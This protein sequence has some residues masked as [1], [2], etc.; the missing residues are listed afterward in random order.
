MT[1]A[2]SEPD[3]I[4]FVDPPVNELAVSLFHLPLLEL[5]AQH[6]GLYWSRIRDRFPLCE[7]QPIVA[8][9]EGPMFMEPAPGEMFPLQ[10]FWFFSATHPTLIQL[11]RNAFM[12]NW[13][14]RPTGDGE[15]PHYEAVI[16]D[17]WQELGCYSTFLS[18]TINAT[19]DVVQRCELTYVNFIPKN[20]FFTAPSEVTTILPWLAGLSNL[21]ED[22]RQLSGLNATVI[23]RV[24][25]DMLVDI[26]I[27]LGQRLDTRDLGLLLELR[28]HGTPS[29]LSLTGA[30]EWYERAHGAIYQLFRK[31]TS[32]QMQ[33][34]IWK[35]R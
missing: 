14:R 32:I 34:D 15:Y 27:R 17:F 2:P 1:A 25:K 30:R 11:Q 28:A 19:L 12:L 33:E 26:T 16:H 21:A 4:K 6:V 35:I 10:R 7:Q 22:D 8:V 5:K 23:H 24:S 20:A 9:P 31:S 29:D 18:E 13:R 3:R